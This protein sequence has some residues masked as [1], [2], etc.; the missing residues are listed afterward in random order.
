[1]WREELTYEWRGENVRLE[2]EGGESE[3]GEKERKRERQ[4][5]RE[6][7]WVQISKS[8]LE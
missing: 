6:G 2:E 7:M 1:M 5:S 3:R 4:K 8:H